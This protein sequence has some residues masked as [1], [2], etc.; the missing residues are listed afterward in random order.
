MLPFELTKDT[1]YLAL[2]GELWSVFYEYFNRNWPCY[3]G[4][5][6]YMYGD[7][8]SDRWNDN[9]DVLLFLGLFITQ[10]VY[11]IGVLVQS[12]VLDFCIICLNQWFP[13][14]DMVSEVADDYIHDTFVSPVGLISET[15]FSEFILK[16]LEYICN[17][18]HPLALRWCRWSTWRCNGSGYLQ[19]YYIPSHAVIFWFELQMG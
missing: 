19:L 12:L 13:P 15:I 7:N 2:S 11:C 17:L 6:L 18:Y 8:T 16:M 5:L 3:K 9:V 1:P 10:T 4:F 14:N